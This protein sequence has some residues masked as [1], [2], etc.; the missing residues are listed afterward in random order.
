M[1]RAVGYVRVSTDGD[2]QATSPVVQRAM[3][4]EECARQ[5]WELAAVFE[6]KFSGGSLDRPDFHELTSYL[7]THQVDLLIVKDLSRFGRETLDYLHFTRTFLEPRGIELYLLRGVNGQD[8]T[9]E[10]V[11]L[12]DMW[13]GERYRLD[14]IRK[15]K[16]A[17]RTCAGK[18]YW[19]G[20]IPYG[21]YSSK[22]GRAGELGQP[23]K[24]CI[25]QPD[26]ETAPVVRQ[27]FSWAA[28]GMRARATTS[29]LNLQGIPS[30]RGAQWSTATVARIVRNKA[31]IGFVNYRGTCLPGE[32]EALVD[33]ET[34]KRAQNNKELGHVSRVPGRYL[35]T[36]MYC[37][38][39]LRSNGLP[40]SFYGMTVK[41]SRRYALARRDDAR[42]SAAKPIRPGL[43]FPRTLDADI[44]EAA[45][46]DC[47]KVADSAQ[48]LPCWWV[49][50]QQKDEEL[51]NRDETTLDALRKELRRLG[52]ERATTKK[53]FHKALD[54]NL[55]ADARELSAHIATIDRQAE[56]VKLE[57]SNLEA[58]IETHK[59]LQE[60]PQQL[61]QHINVIQLLQETGNHVA[62][63]EA[64]SI[65]INRIFITLNDADELILQIELRL[66]A[67]G[68]ER[69]GRESNP[70]RTVLSARNWF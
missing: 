41:G 64:L 59:Q 43:V 63:R 35:L 42:E 51:I 32:H 23:D 13:I 14:V 49:E 40:L 20:V 25:L 46:L 50:I 2:D 39:Y 69:R 17:M 56:T 6:D 27:I 7:D 57:V 48:G 11:R 55:E 66:E 4:E 54:F 62:L 52:Q 28:E 67:Y 22:L 53:R 65:L 68:K 31:Y 10:L 1:K 34:W 33:E 29:R 5:G 36:R 9:V 3:I 44:V 18:G 47:F 58:R 70:P 12:I 8:G 16:D 38:L 21:Y 15:T 30:P 60:M 37:P 24:P 19:A 26:P 45:V 61:T